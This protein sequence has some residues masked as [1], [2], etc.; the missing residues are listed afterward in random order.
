[1]T[2]VL[3]CWVLHAYR[4]ADNIIRIDLP[5]NAVSSAKMLYGDTVF[6]FPGKTMYAFYAGN[7]R[8]VTISEHSRRIM[9]VLSIPDGDTLKSMLEYGSDGH[10]LLAPFAEL[11]GDTLIIRDPIKKMLAV[12]DMES[13][14]G[15]GS[16]NCRFI[17]YD[18]ESETMSLPY[19]FPYGNRLAALNPYCFRSPDGKISNPDTRRFI[20]S[21]SDMTFPDIKHDYFTQNVSQGIVIAN[22]ASGKIV[23]LPEYENTVEIFDYNS[24]SKTHEIH[25]PADF[26]NRFTAYGNGMVLTSGYVRNRHLAGAGCDGWFLSAFSYGNQVYILKLDWDGHLKDSYTISCTDPYCMSLSED[27]SSMFLMQYLQ[28]DRLAFIRYEL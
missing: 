25:I 27:G 15:D 9:S 3:T 18:M 17:N 4:P 8:T 13:I 10:R 24:L 14:A 7:N 28:E 2:A 20:S 12:M 26:A 21:D 22:P 23:F 5:D 6:I 19:I 16:G 1:M 11:Y